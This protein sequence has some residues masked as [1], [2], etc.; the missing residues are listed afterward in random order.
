[1]IDIELDIKG[2]LKCLPDTLY[3]ERLEV[4]DRQ[5]SSGIIIPMEDMRLNQRFIKPRWARVYKKADNITNVNVGDW[6]LLEHGKWS[7]ALNII[8]NNKQVKLWY[9]NEKNYK[10]GIIGIRQEEPEFMR[11]YL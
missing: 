5:T 4:G 11:E 3:V 7:T 10:S 2:N 1:M 6:V 9:I 8:D